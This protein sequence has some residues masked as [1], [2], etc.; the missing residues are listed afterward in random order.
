MNDTV[1]STDTIGLAYFSRYFCVI[2]AFARIS[3][4]ITPN[5]RLKLYKSSFIKLVRAGSAIS[6]TL[7]E[8]NFAGT[9]FHTFRQLGQNR[10]I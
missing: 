6:Y 2:V 10:Q 8:E 5:Y 4:N 9:K 7:K 3:K 1:Y